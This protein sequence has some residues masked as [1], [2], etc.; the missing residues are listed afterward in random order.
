MSLRQSNVNRSLDNQFKV[1]GFE[2]VDLL[3]LLLVTGFLKV[4][5][6]GTG[7]ETYFVWIPSGVMALV[8]RI[9]KRGKPDGYLK[10]LLKY[11]LGPKHFAAFKWCKNWE[12]PFWIKTQSQRIR[13]GGK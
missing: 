11:H 7:L 10:H 1:M 8:L 6:T 13:L 3:A 9:A 2:A 5:F 12:P 4:I